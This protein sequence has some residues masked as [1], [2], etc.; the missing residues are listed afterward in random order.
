MKP[1]TQEP[2]EGKV[3]GGSGAATAFDHT[4]LPSRI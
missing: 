1:L 3:W 4:P 2:P